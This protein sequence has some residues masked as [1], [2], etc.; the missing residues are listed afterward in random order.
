MSRARSAWWRR[1]GPRSTALA[2]ALAAVLAGG[3]RSAPGRCRR[4]GR[5]RRASRRRCA[6]CS[7]LRVVE[8]VAGLVA[9]QRRRGDLREQ[10]GA[11]S[12]RPPRGRPAGCARR[13]CGR[14]SR[15][16]VGAERA[17]VDGHEL[18]RLPCSPP[19]RRRRGGRRG[20]RRLERR[21]GRRWSR[22]PR[23][24]RCRSR[25]RRGRASRRGRG[26]PRR[27]SCASP[28]AVAQP[29]LGLGGEHQQVALALP[30]DALH[31][32]VV[33]ADR[34]HDGRQRGVEV[35]A[36]PGGDGGALARVGV[37]RL[38]A[39]EASRRPSPRC[40]RRRPRRRGRP[41]RPG[42]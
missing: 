19:R 5:L 12:R 2:P 10:R 28:V 38:Q 16:P 15:G 18:A 41:P 30:A 42:A 33:R 9:G 35:G 13:S 32:A 29:L 11:G 26:A 25:A 22:R 34:Q 3:E 36:D 31:L 14:R 20:P 6:T 21:V 40:P 8:R 17:E 4:R 24:G 23:P 37:E 39:G 1:A 7:M 27:C